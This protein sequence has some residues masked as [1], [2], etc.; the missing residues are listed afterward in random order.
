ML[1]FLWRWKIAT[2]KNLAARFYNGKCHWTAYKRLLRLEKANYLTS[3][4]SPTGN[5]HFW[6]LS[7][8]SFN[9][10]VKPKLSG[11][12]QVGYKSESIEHDFLV[13]AAHL[14]NWVTGSPKGNA[15]YTEQQ[16][17]RI[18]SEFYPSWVPRSRIHRPD[19]YSLIST[20]EQTRLVSFE[21]ELSQ[22][23]LEIYENVGRFYFED[24]KV[25]DVL[26]IVNTPTQA[27]SIQSRFVKAIGSNAKV[28]SYLLLSDFRKYHW[29]T[30]IFTGKQKGNR[31]ED[32]IGNTVGAA[33]EQVPNIEFFDCRKSLKKSR[34]NK[35]IKN[36]KSLNRVPPS[37]SL[38]NI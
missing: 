25:D 11:L 37:G 7:D 5:E 6:T 35:P 24:T 19:G 18:E 36:Q 31:L 23:S 27:T 15:F 12:V 1:F 2:S 14:G 33:R 34:H 9:S 16:L 17:R 29:Q 32:V 3:I 28:H 22:K 8:Q 38:S 20:G 26:W 13:N 21:I 4:W 30:P 10:I